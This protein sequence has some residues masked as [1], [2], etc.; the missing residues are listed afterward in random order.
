MLTS[1]HEAEQVAKEWD[2]PTE[3][4]L[5][6]TLNH[7]GLSNPD[8]GQRTRIV[9]TMQT[10]PDDQIH[11]ILSLRRPDSP[12]AIRDGLVTLGD[13]PFARI[14]RL[15]ADDAVLGYWRNGARVLTLNSNA[16]SQCVGCAF[17]PNTLEDAADPALRSAPDLAAYFAAV[18]AGQ[19]GDMSGVDR[20]TVCTGCFR[21]EPLAL[22]HLTRVRGLMHAHA[23]GGVL[24]FLSSVLETDEGL[25]A[26]AELGPFHLTLTAEC[27]TG[28]RA[29]LKESKARLTPD[30]MESVLRRAK[31]VGLMTDFT[32]IV[33]L[34]P[35]A[36]AARGLERLAEHST[37]FP[38]VQ[39][40]QAHTSLMD[41]YLQPEARQIGYYLKLRKWLE[42]LF[43]PSGLRPK[44]WENYR[45][46]WYFQFGREPLVG[47]RI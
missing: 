37:T 2:V 27:F 22:E 20:I 8:L 34:D 28:R 43:G 11:L 6:I 33:G 4:V 31:A 47:A 7:C 38:R 14:D 12:F 17:C 32:Y 45:S 35:Y 30:D 41:V 46:L 3:D 18:S 10:R 39:V 1:L 36:D 25:V 19:G 42:K 16:R 13:E 44:P 21:F 24:H 5:L 26:A 9:L 23:C 40:Y 29:I 15:A